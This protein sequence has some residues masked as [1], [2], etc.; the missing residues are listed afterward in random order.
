MSRKWC[1]GLLMLVVAAVL[2]TGFRNLGSQNQ[3]PTGETGGVYDPK[4]LVS[5]HEKIIIEF[6]LPPLTVRDSGI[7]GVRGQLLKLM[8]H[9]QSAEPGKP[10]LPLRGFSLGVPQDARPTLQILEQQTGMMHIPD[11]PPAPR[12]RFK[13]NGKPDEWDKNDIESEMT[14]ERDEGTYRKNGY[15][16][17]EPARLGTDAIMRGQRIQTFQVSPVQYNPV[18]GQV[19]YYKRLKIAVYYNSDA[20]LHKTMAAENAPEAFE[21]IFKS[22]LLNYDIA[23]NWRSGP[24][25]LKAAADNYFLTQGSN[26]CKLYLNKPGIYTLAKSDLDAAGFNLG[27]A[28]V[29]NIKMFNKGV[30][31]AIR[32]LDGNSNGLFDEGDTIEFYG[33][34]FKNYYTA[35][36][37][38]WLTEGTSA[39]KRMAVRDGTPNAGVPSIS[40]GKF[41]YSKEIDLGRN[42]TYPGHTD[43]ERWFMEPVYAPTTRSH[44]FDMKNVV[45]TGTNDCVF[46]LKAIGIAENASIN[47]DHH[48]Q[49]EINDN[50]VLD[51]SWDGRTFLIANNSFSQ[52]YLLEGTNKIEIIGPGDTGSSTDWFLNDFFKVEYWR[53]NAAV[54][55]SVV[56]TAFASGDNRL[57]LSGFSAATIDV[58]DISDSNNVVTYEN[59]LRYDDIVE[60]QDNISTSRTY[61]ALSQEKKRKPDTIV[62]DVGAGLRSALS[63]DFVVLA[64]AEFINEA[65][66]LADFHADDGLS[67]K[68]IDVQDI[69]DEFNYGFYEDWAIRKFFEYANSSWSRLPTYALL[70]GDASWNPRILN[71]ASYGS[72]RSD[73]IPTRLFEAVEDN[74]EAASDN[75]F[76]CVQGDD[77]LPDVLIGRLPAR[78]SLQAGVMVAKVMNYATDFTAGEWN[79]TATFVADDNE[80][81]VMAFEDSSAAFI[82]DLVPASFAKKRIF[83]S[84]VGKSNMKTS[85]KAA[86]NDGTLIVNYLGH[87]TVSTWAQEKY[88]ERADVPTLRND[89]MA[90][91]L[92]TLSCINGYFVD[93][94]DENHSMA[95]ALIRERQRGAVTIFS[96]SGEAYPSPVLA[97]GR[98]LYGSLFRENNTIVGSFSNTG[99]VEMYARYPS[100]PDHV[101]FYILYGDPATKLHYQP[102]MNY[103]AAGYTGTVMLAGAPAAGA[104]IVAQ[105]DGRTFGGTISQADGV[106]APFY[107]SADNPATAMKEGGAAGDTVVFRA[108]LSKGDTVQLYPSALWKGGQVQQIALRDVATGIANDL[109]IEFYV[110]EKKVGDEFYPDDPAPANALFSAIITSSERL[111]PSMFELALNDQVMDADSYTLQ[112]DAKNPTALRMAFQPQTLAD[113][114]HELKIRSAGGVSQMAEETMVFRVQSALSL[115]DVVNFP[116]PMTDESKFTFMLRNDKAAAVQIKIY[117]VAGRLIRV[118]DA[119]YMSVGYSESDVW[120]GTDEYGDKLANGAYFYK[121]IADDG[122]ERAEVIEKLVV[123]R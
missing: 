26:W 68:V 65:A 119:G 112:P 75:W 30:E 92:V 57:L 20:A 51:R 82:N 54:N 42:A 107:V 46:K 94:K 83:P 95:E 121:I 69:Y 21:N 41:T 12:L 106:L 81:G 85:I 55:D 61:Y 43:N 25:L 66:L 33:T 123:M 32:V 29:S 64:H 80:G 6:E 23:K 89:N 47:P 27:G 115:E 13:R 56:L 3:S 38:Y 122:E 111:E 101:M 78:T 36:N 48:V 70:L 17:A 8:G 113:G 74:F 52:N 50:L 59:A 114:R 109:R 77:V 118:I 9:T 79:N 99:L 31:I 91:Y 117:T 110:N 102:A 104:A 44:S 105:I 98:K 108:V 40:Y 10:Q 14:Y 24:G 39:G 7:Q 87:G 60:F 67:T 73:Y 49:V 90:P 45:A 63:L 97:M 93:P 35:T 16:P 100:L 76:G 88:F 58:Y 1:Y 34:P 22:T 96:G 2:F 18:S 103:L 37:I 116:N 120:D 19:K 5:D 15:Y 86:I 72:A 71:P 62:K 11:I 84:V 53:N 28:N 4:I